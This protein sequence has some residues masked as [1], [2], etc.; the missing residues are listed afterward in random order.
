VR[1]EVNSATVLM[2]TH[3]ATGQADGAAGEGAQGAE[4]PE[5]SG[6]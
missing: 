3:L 6:Q 1:K 4:Q 2:C 5:T